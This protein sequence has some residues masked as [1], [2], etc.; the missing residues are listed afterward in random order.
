MVWALYEESPAFDRF[1]HGLERELLGKTAQGPVKPHVT[2][3]RFKEFSDYKNLVLEK[4][5]FPQELEMV[6]LNF[7]ESI[8]KPEGPVYRIIRSFDL[9]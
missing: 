8:L 1:Y 4:T 9:L 5:E 7:Y 6:R 2:L 3:A